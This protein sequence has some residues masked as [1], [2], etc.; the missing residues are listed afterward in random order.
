MARNKRR[1]A[2]R[3]EET[4]QRSRYLAERELFNEAHARLVGTRESDPTFVRRTRTDDQTTY[5]LRGPA[6]DSVLSALAQRRAAFVEQFGRE[7]GPDDP[8]FFA[9]GRSE[10]TA[11]TEE[12]V[13]AELSRPGMAE[14]LGLEPAFLNAFVELKYAVTDENRHLFSAQEVAEFERAVARHQQRTD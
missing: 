9:P 5:E 2:K 11:I 4:K 6:G 12:W 7:P 3:V 1:R 8:V 13:M 14:E 10:P